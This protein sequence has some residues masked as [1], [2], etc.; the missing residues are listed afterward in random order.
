MDPIN[1]KLPLP[2]RM[3]PWQK[4]SNIQFGTYLVGACFWL[5]N[6]RHDP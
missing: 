3:E 1:K 6:N 4:K 2:L 5:G